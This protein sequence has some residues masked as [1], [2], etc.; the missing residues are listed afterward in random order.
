M[1]LA[2]Q[3]D[4]IR[5]INV[6][7]PPRG[8]VMSLAE[9]YLDETEAGG[10]RPVL[11]V[12]GLA[13]R[14]DDAIRQSQAWEEMLSKWGLPFFHMTDC[15]TKSGVFK[16]LSANEC[17]IAAREAIGIIRDTVSAYVRVSVELSAFAEELKIIAHLGGAYEWCAISALPAISRWCD[18][19]NDV[20]KVH[21]FFE[22]GA[23]AQANASYRIS[24][25]VSDPMIR[26]GCKYSGMSFVEKA[27]SP[28][29][30]AADI[31]AWHCGKDAKRAFAGQPMRNDLV[32]L[33]QGKP[34]YGGHWTREML[35]AVS[36]GASSVAAELSLPTE[37][38]PEIDR[39]SR[40]TPKS[41][42]SG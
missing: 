16:H 14:K 4:A 18:A 6:V 2:G 7:V 12:A 10:E 36:S 37:M 29:V 21:Y 23:V 33:I 38:L 22:G 27:S 15:A 35:K 40:R 26:E 5:V 34:V 3:T 31:V 32:A 8:W 17:D 42:R 9:C 39:L 28:G 19:S 13:F 30:Q 20:S 24:E 25:M 11:A 41:G 1:P